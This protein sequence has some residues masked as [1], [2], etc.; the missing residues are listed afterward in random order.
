MT[1]PPRDPGDIL[2]GTFLI[3][4]GLTLA[5]A[6]GACS[7]AWVSFLFGN[8]AIESGLAAYGLFWLFVAIVCARLGILAVEG[9]IR[10][11]WGQFGVVSKE[12]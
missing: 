2:A 7:V 5:L 8:G 3:L 9:G 4:F 11:I 10:S 6:G 1:R 12:P